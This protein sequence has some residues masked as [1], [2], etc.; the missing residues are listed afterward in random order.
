MSEIACLQ[1]RRRGFDSN[2]FFQTAHQELQETSDLNREDAVMNHANMVR[3][4]V[5]GLQ[6]VLQ[7]E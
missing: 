3:N 1:Y 5:T 4:V 6:E 2:S 7:R